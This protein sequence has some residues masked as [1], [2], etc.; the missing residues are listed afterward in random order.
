MMVTT[1]T[2]CR[3]ICGS[4]QIVSL[5]PSAPVV[6]QLV[7]E[8]SV[9]F[10]VNNLPLRRLGLVTVDSNPYILRIVWQRYRGV[11]FPH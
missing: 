9:G 1:T 6:A 2:I 3:Q 4:D 7:P 10:I 8:I 5:M 11:V